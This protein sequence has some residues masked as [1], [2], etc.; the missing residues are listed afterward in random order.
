M[1]GVFSASTAGFV[2]QVVVGP[3]QAA[4]RRSYGQGWAWVFRAAGEALGAGGQ[5]PV[6]PTSTSPQHSV[7]PQWLSLAEANNG[8]ERVK[9]TSLGKVGGKGQDS[10]EHKAPGPKHPPQLP[11]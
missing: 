11:E 7:A 8:E 4:E 5:E 10:A 3:G 9:P 6:L 1:P 2:L